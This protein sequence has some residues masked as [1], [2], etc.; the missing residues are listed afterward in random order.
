MKLRGHRR[1]FV[2]A[3]AYR[4]LAVRMV[5][6]P[7]RYEGV[8]ERQSSPIPERE[9]H[10]KRR[11]EDAHR[12]VHWPEQSNRCRARSIHGR[13]SDPDGCRVRHRGGG[14]DPRPLVYSA[15]PDPRSSS[16]SA[17]APSTDAGGLGVRRDCVVVGF[18]CQ[19]PR[20]NV[21]G[22]DAGGSLA[23]ERALAHLVDGRAK[24]VAPVTTR[25]TVASADRHISRCTLERSVSAGPDVY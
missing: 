14:R 19:S 9:G 7:Y 5:I 20:G 3:G 17:S 15:R 18:A 11:E 2:R 16:S 25:G 8:S 12:P 10:R 22:P 24:P 4:S 23:R 13:G 1:W 6:S 21:P